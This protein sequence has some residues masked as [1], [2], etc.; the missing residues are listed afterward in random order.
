MQQKR[1]SLYDIEQFLRDAGAE[2]VN[3]KAVQSF[4]EELEST[5]KEL[6]DEAEV[7]AKYAGRERLVTNSDISMVA[8]CR[9]RHVYVRKV[10]RKP[11]QRARAKV[12]FRRPVLDVRGMKGSTAMMY[13][14]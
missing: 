10:R 1:F 12:P 7:Y 5:V 14:K 9:P 13:E 8:T 11:V 3:E 6:V 2:R 4:E